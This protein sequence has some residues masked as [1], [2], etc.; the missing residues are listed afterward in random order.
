LLR[1]KVQLQKDK[2]PLAATTCESTQP[3][4]NATTQYGTSAG[5]Q[6][7]ETQPPKIFSP[8]PGNCVGHSLKNLAPLRKLFAP[9]HVPSWLRA[10]TFVLEFIQS[11][12][13]NNCEKGSTMIT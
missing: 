10:C 5:M 12:A 4:L 7:E 13:K 6:P 8:P 3:T 9:P 2:S 11:F 1:C